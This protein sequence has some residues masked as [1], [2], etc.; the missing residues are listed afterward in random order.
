MPL[1]YLRHVRDALAWLKPHEVRQQIEQPVRIGLHAAS[2]LSYFQME[3]FLCGQCSDA[4]RAELAGTLLRAGA[5]PTPGQY[6]I[7]LWSDDLPTAGGGFGFVWQKPELT[8]KQILRDREHLQ[9]P[10]ARSFPPFRKPVADRV[11]RTVARENA[12]FSVATALPDIIPL[13]S[14]P[15]AVGE[16]AS[17]TA[18]LTA[19]QIRMAFLLGAASDRAIGYREQRNEI[20]SIVAGAFGWRAMARELAGHIPLGGG[21]IPKAAIAYAG[22]RVVG[23]SLERLYRIGYGLTRAERRIAWDQAFERGKKVAANIIDTVKRRRGLPAP[24]DMVSSPE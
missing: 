14:I 22:T 9:L 16:F 17:D 2:D 21:L 23:L 3:S 1:N 18:F 20:G 10:L 19:N 11:I 13:F 15:W 7:D 5:E 4:R 12:M 6:D 8:V 24:Q